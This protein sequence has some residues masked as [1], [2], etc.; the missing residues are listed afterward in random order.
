[1]LGREADP[2]RAAAEAAALAPCAEKFL[3][4]ITA[5]ASDLVRQ[6]WA[7]VAPAGAQG[8][9]LEAVVQDL[10]RAR[11]EDQQADVLTIRIPPGLD[12]AAAIAW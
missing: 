5:D 12:T 8:A 7:V 2:G 3:A 10:V 11:A 6:G 4:D 1:M 9:R